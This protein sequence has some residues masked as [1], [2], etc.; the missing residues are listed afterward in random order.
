MPFNSFVISAT[1]YGP[2]SNTMLFGSPYNFYIL[3][4]NSLASPS[5]NVSFV[6]ATK[7]IILDNLLQTTRIISF[8]ATIGNFVIKSTIR[9]VHGFS[10]TSLSFNF[11]ATSSVLF[12]IF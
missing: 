4:L 8:S 6:V 7:C 11:P 10:G 3:S 12:F 2:L 9:C 5:A 1:N